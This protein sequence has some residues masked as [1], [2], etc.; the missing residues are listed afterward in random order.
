[1]RVIEINTTAFK[2]ENF[3]L[4]TSLSDNQIH[5]VLSPLLDIARNGDNEYTNEDLFDALRRI[6][7]NELI[8]LHYKFEIISL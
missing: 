1:M 8:E 7:P 6:F 4:L 2:E 5:Q 3:F